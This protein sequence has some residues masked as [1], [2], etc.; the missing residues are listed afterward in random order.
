MM[1]VLRRLSVTLVGM[2]REQGEGSIEP[3]GI[4]PDGREALAAVS[5][6]AGTEEHFPVGRDT[7]CPR[8]TGSTHQSFEV[9]PS[10][11]NAAERSGSAMEPDRKKVFL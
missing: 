9:A 4:G 10:Y 3:T 2:E 1:A 8:G 11:C 5:R 6:R 7:A